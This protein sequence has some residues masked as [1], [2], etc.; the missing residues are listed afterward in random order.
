[1]EQALEFCRTRQLPLEFREKVQKYYTFKEETLMLVKYYNIFQTMPMSLQT[2]ISLALN[3]ELIS[4]VNLFNLGSPS[5][6]QAI[7]R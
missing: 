1:M 2:E 6:L 3:K 5:F 4:R 7:A